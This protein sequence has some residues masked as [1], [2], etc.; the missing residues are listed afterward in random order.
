MTEK[1]DKFVYGAKIIRFGGAIHKL[2]D[3][4]FVQEGWR[5][6]H[7]FH[8]FRRWGDDFDQLEV[9]KR[10]GATWKVHIYYNVISDFPISKYIG[11]VDVRELPP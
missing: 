2:S 11:Y 3:K 5:C 10:C 9:C 8:S 7:D 1:L 6:R 4:S